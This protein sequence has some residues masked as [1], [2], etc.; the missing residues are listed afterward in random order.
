VFSGRK[1]ELNKPYSNVCFTF[2][3]CPSCGYLLWFVHRYKFHW[4]IVTL[5]YAKETK[6]AQAAGYRNY[7]EGRTV[8]VAAINDN[9]TVTAL[10]SGLHRISWGA[11][12][13][14]VVVAIVVH[15]AL[16]MLG[17][18]I[19]AAT[20]NPL[21]ESDPLAGLGTGA[22]MWMAGSALL[23]MFSG[24]WVAGRL[25]GIPH[26]LDG[27]LHG[28]VTWGLTMIITLLMI[29]SGVGS[30]INTAASAIG[31]GLNMV[32]QSASDVAPEVAT[33]LE[34]QDIS[35]QG[36]REEVMSLIQ[37]QGT[38]LSGASSTSTTP[39]TTTTAPST[40]TTNGATVPSSTGAT[41][42]PE[43]MTAAQREADFTISQFLM[44]GTDATPE[45]RTEVVNLLTTRAN[46]TEEQAQQTVDRWQQSYQQFAAQVEE[47]TRQAGEALADAVAK[48]AGAA[49][50]LMLLG[51]F[52]A[53]GGG[54]VGAPDDLSDVV[55]TETVS[56][57]AAS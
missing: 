44:S 55:E 57:T 6:M 11:V 21:T 35:L 16:S 14:G 39:D 8:P 22:V 46:M 52:A 31:Q 3:R 41:F 49:F 4:F 53:A 50:M 1:L 17:L 56:P 32:A 37:P 23:A 24:G 30:A 5:I 40:T 19:G 9:V 10:P 15:V 54:H 28:I 27:A 25:A 42:D 36:V 29:S 18:S 26:H 43:N 51:A 47:T 7:P 33:A 12:L 20:V 13:A 38:E 48:M 34:R 45:A 2:L